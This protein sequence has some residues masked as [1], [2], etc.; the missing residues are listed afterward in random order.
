MT[1]D[2]ARNRQLGR[3]LSAL[4]GDENPSLAEID[5][6]RATK[7]VPI[8]FIRPNAKQPRRNFDPEQIESLVASVRER[9]ILQPILVRRDPNNPAQYEIVAGERR[10][11]AAQRAR[12]HEIPVIVKDLTDQ[13]ALEIALVENIQRQDLNPLE[14]AE[15][16]R[17][18]VDEFSHTQDAISRAV[19]KSRSH[20]ANMMRLLN[21][22][23]AV[24]RMLVT[25]DLTMGH[26]RALLNAKDAATLAHRIVKQ[27][28]N[29]RQA[30][31][32][33]ARE[34]APPRPGVPPAA[35]KDPNTAA[36]ETDLSEL[37]GL[38]VSIKFRGAGGELVVH[39]Q[40]LDQLDEVLHRLKS[41][42]QPVNRN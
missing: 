27:G 32:L 6:D 35:E 30:E 33:V 13:D 37:L 10:W 23:D 14:E 7:T 38:K 24:K 15:G 5:A 17:R 25:G 42:G 3:G 18:L 4:F 40:T 26:A 8:E 12:L 19:G 16:Y 29:V 20:V 22:P 28:L 1:D 34:A 41:T 11:R 21:L 31:K 2:K 9:G 36:L 39:Y